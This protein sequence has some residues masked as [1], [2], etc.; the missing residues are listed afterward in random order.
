MIK[1]YKYE[2]K[3]ITVKLWIDEHPNININ[4]SSFIGKTVPICNDERWENKKMAV[5]VYFG[6]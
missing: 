4:N 6:S 3:F 1:I 5:E 2:E